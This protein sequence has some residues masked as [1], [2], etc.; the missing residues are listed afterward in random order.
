MHLTIDRSIRTACQRNACRCFK[1][2][3]FPCNPGI[4]FQI[5]R[6]CY[7]LGIHKLRIQIQLHVKAIS[8]HIRR[9]SNLQ[10]IA[11]DSTALRCRIGIFRLCTARCQLIDISLCRMRK[12]FAQRLHLIICIGIT[13][14]RERI[15]NEIFLRHLHHHVIRTPVKFKRHGCHATF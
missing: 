13:E 1:C 9:N 7:R 3:F 6:G 2:S 12:Q 8:I 5:C 14:Q 11:T 10:I 15:L 4:F